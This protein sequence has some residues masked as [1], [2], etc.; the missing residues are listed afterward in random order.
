M[1][2]LLTRTP[3]SAIKRSSP[4]RGSDRKTTLTGVDDILTGAGY[5]RVFQDI[6]GKYRSEGD[7][8]MT[9]PLRGPLNPTAVDHSTD[10]YDT[11][12]WLIKNIRR[13]NGR[14]GMIGTSYD[15]FL[16]L[17]RLVNPHPALK[18]AVAINP[19]VD[20]W[21][22][23]DW[24]HKGAFRRMMMDCIRIQD[25]SYRSITKYEDRNVD[26][27]DLYLSA[28]S[29]GELCTIGASKITI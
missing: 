18:A 27:Y 19:L 9:R 29:A 2:I 22:G 13:N 23:D 20:A 12:E 3:Y 24:F 21:I 28:G 17:M 4:E 8:V 1:P 7:Y 26:E 10:A 16:V 5:I 25:P 15:G 11:I 6:R 14:I